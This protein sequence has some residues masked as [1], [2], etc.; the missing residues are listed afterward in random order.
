[1]DEHSTPPPYDAI[2]ARNAAEPSK[3]GQTQA[4]TVEV[5]PANTRRLQ[6]LH[7]L[8]LQ[9]RRLLRRSPGF[10]PRRISYRKANRDCLKSYTLPARCTHCGLQPSKMIPL[11]YTRGWPEYQRYDLR[12]KY[13]SH[14]PPT[15]KDKTERRSC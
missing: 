5:V 14:V 15:K 9:S 7:L 6:T 4:P 8:Y 13:E 1:M 3:I 12:F 10:C 11:S 2:G